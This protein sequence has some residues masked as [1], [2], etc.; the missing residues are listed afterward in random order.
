MSA[1]S[2][3]P[4]FLL[5]DNDHTMTIL[6]ACKSDGTRMKPRFLD[7]KG[8]FE[9]SGKV[10]LVAAAMQENFVILHMALS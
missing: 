1:A 4:N 5:I 10:G 2:L 8:I 9:F 3:D 7:Q 6:P